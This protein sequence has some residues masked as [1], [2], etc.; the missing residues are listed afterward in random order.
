MRSARQQRVLR[1]EGGS[2]RNHPAETPRNLPQ[3]PGGVQEDI[4]WQNPPWAGPG[5][6]PRPLLTALAVR[7]WFM[8]R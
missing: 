7:P 1:G 8:P 4:G 6:G 3:P 5:P 2:S